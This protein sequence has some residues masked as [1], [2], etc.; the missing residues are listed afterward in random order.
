MM[1]NRKTFLQGLTNVRAHK[2]KYPSKN[3]KKMDILTLNKALQA[4][5]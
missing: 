4:I 3:P 5:F 1:N 2:Q